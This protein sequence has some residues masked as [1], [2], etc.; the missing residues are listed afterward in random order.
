MAV[1]TIF[2]ADVKKAPVFETFN[3]EVSAKI[4]IQSTTYYY[5]VL[6][7]AFPLCESSPVAHGI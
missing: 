4:P 6:L 5:Q 2:L 3:N 1:N 7:A